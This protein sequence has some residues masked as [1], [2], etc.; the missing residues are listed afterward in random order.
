MSFSF[1]TAKP[2]PVTVILTT[3]LPSITLSL[4]QPWLSSLLR[5][6]LPPTALVRF[7][8]IQRK[9]KDGRKDE[10]NDNILCLR[11]WAGRNIDLSICWKLECFC[12][13][14]LQKELIETYP[15][16]LGKFHK[17]HPNHSNGT[18]LTK[19]SRLRN[20][21]KQPPMPQSKDIQVQMWTK[22]LTSGG[23]NTFLKLQKTTVKVLYP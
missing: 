10:M 4:F 12:S 3:L 20:L 9:K 23:R 19:W 6:H 2:A 14:K 8:Q 18:N 22:S 7:Q 11:N 5:Y 21:K 13:R 15:N 16:L 1:H 17:P